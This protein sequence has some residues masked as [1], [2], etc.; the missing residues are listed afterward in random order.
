[1]MKNRAVSASEEEIAMNLDDELRILRGISPF[2]EIDPKALKLLAFAS[3]RMIFLAGQNLF[4]EGDQASAAYVI[5][6]GSADVFQTTANGIEKVGEVHEQSVVGE[7]ALLCDKPRQTTVT[8]TS[9]VNALQIT[10]DSFQKLMS[11]CPNTM[12]GI[13][14]GLGERMSK[15]S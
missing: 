5:L 2:S 14:S 8:A 4:A 9:T 15:V 6:S 10:K 1:M 3:D 11:C 7:F 12:A 13:L